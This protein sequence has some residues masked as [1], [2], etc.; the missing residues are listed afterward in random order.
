[1]GAMVYLVILLLTAAWFYQFLAL[2]CL[3]R[4]FRPSAEAPPVATGPGITVF[5]PLKGLEP[6]SRECLTSFLTQDY[7]PYQVLFGVREPENPVLDTPPGITAGPSP[8][9]SGS[10]HLSGRSGP[11]P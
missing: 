5:K 2:I 7:H 8:V 4:F 3:G 9:R 11:Q 6:L 1:M 10:G